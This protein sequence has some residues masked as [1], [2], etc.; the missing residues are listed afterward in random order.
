MKDYSHVP[1]GKGKTTRMIYISE[2]TNYPILVCDESRKISTQ[3]YAAEL[4]AMIPDPI[5]VGELFSERSEGKSYKNILVDDSRDILMAL[6][7]GRGLEV[8]AIC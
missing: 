1:R 6:L 7:K 4:N 8:D 3:R 5:T 2:Y